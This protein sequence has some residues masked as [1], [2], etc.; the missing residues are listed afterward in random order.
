MTTTTKTTAEVLADM[1]TENTGRSLLDSGDAYGRNYERH[2]GKTVADFMRKPEMRII[3]NEPELDA[4]HWLLARVTYD[5]ELDAEFQKYYDASDDYALNDMATWPETIGADDVK[6]WNTYDT[7][8][9]LSQTL[10][11]ATFSYDGFDFVLLQ[12]HG[13]CDIRGGYTRPRLF[14]VSDINDMFDYQNVT[15]TCYECRFYAWVNAYGYDD[16]NCGERCG[17]A[18]GNISNWIPNDI[19]PN[20]GRPWEL[21]DGCPCCG[22]AW[23]N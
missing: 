20:Y 11:F 15:V 1:F 16:S 21:G 13:G 17:D 5:P 4:F 10:Q 19:G 14:S 7:D 9:Y 2:A 18:C 22:T 12:V 23:D 6:T 8:G 3:D